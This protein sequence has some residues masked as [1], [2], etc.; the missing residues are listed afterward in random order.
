[1]S[2]EKPNISVSVVHDL[3][4]SILD[5][6]PT[7]NPGGLES[8]LVQICK[9]LVKSAQWFKFAVF[10][11]ADEFAWHV[12]AVQEGF[13]VQLAPTDIE[14]LFSQFVK[15]KVAES[16]IIFLREAD[17]RPF[18]PEERWDA[19]I[20][21]SC[22]AFPVFDCGK[23]ESVVIAFSEGDRTYEGDGAV[24]MRQVL[25]TLSSNC[26]LLCSIR[27]FKSE[28]DAAFIDGRGKSKELETVRQDIRE[29]LQELDRQVKINP[30][31]TVSVSELKAL[32]AQGV[33]DSLRFADESHIRQLERSAMFEDPYFSR[34]VHMGLDDTRVKALVGVRGSNKTGALMAVRDWIASHG[35]DESRLVVIDFEES[36]FRRFKTADDVLGFLDGL[37]P[38]NLQR[39]LFLDEIS[40]IGWYAE[41]LR[42]LSSMRGWNVWV[43]SST[44]CA[45]GEGNPFAQYDWM[46]VLRIWPSPKLFRPQQV[47]DRIWYQI[48]MSDV[49]CGVVHPDIRAKESLA[50]YFSDHLGELKTTREIASE[51]IVFG[52]RISANSIRTYRKALESAYLIELS[53]V[54]DT[55]ER[56]VVKSYSGRAF[57]SDLELRSWRY[58]EASEHEVA[59][60]A[61]NT[62]YLN[63]RRTYDKVYTPR[64]KDADF[65]TIEPDGS[66]RLWCA[67]FENEQEKHF[68]RLFRGGGGV[69]AKKDE[70][71][72]KISAHKA[73]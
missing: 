14:R 3:I 46:S 5:C 48:F 49:S 71:Q 51:L 58:G 20:C 32:V 39:F 33:S 53:E 61:L 26:G 60:V 16:G 56:E 34:W 23:L 1:M 72:Q 10:I 47:L 38:C 13:H 65:L 64:D 36:R 44:A 27:R 55:F 57:W 68:F 35:V 30:Q 73:V 11:R 17:L 66:I 67:M 69:F 12:P 25:S 4:G 43:A 63:L 70:T 24:A 40:R 54:Y 15:S 18:I 9:I 37:P 59:R 8:P 29:M 2:E 6:I 41:L 7:I 31:Q 50:E 42:R 28:R 62:L 21:H 22:V 52:R 19:W 45:V